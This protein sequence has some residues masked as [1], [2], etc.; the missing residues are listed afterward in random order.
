MNYVKKEIR[1]REEL[2]KLK[3]CKNCRH[4]NITQVLESEE[5]K[6]WRF[7]HKHKKYLE[8]FK[9]CKEYKEEESGDETI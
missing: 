2:N 8:N 3:N 1:T 9:P 6:H 4:Q 7:C 5:H